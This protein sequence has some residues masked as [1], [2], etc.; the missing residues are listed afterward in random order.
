MTSFRHGALV[1]V[2]LSTL[3][4]GPLYAQYGSGRLLENGFQPKSLMRGSQT[5]QVVPKDE[6]EGSLTFGKSKP[7][8]KAPAPNVFASA[9]ASAAGAKLKNCDELSRKVMDALRTSDEIP[10]ELQK[11]FSGECMRDLLVPHSGIKPTPLERNL[12]SILG[13]LRAGSGSPFCTGFR[14]NSQEV[15]TAKHCL[16][17]RETGERRELPAPVTFQLAGAKDTF[18]IKPTG[19]APGIPGSCDFPQSVS[20]FSTADDFLLIKVTGLADLAMPRVQFADRAI[21]EESVLVAGISDDLGPGQKYLVDATPGGCKVGLTE[22]SCV[23]HSCS[24]GRGYSGAPVIRLSAAPTPGVVPVSEQPGV[25]VV[26]MHIEGVGVK[27]SQ[28]NSAAM[29]GVGNAAIL[30]APSQQSASAR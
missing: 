1:G 17:Y 4:Y 19:C 29:R 12:A 10:P 30:L 7:T 15:M 24:T 26:A 20:P 21:S 8:V 3:F 25:V 11:E 28:C 5:D 18:E 13:S 14:I 6:F 9:M 2:A 22:G 23:Y 27:G 16:Y